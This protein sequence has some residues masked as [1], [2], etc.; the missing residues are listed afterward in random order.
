MSESLIFVVHSARHG[1]AVMRG[2]QQAQSINE[3]GGSARVLGARSDRPSLFA[4]RNRTVVLVKDVIIDDELILAL[5]L[6]GNRLVWDAVDYCAHKPQISL[7]E[8]PVQ[9]LAGLAAAEL[10]TDV[11]AMTT[12]TNAV[13]EAAFSGLR[14]VHRVDHQIDRRLDGTV[15]QEP[16]DSFGVGYFGAPEN[17]PAWAD[18]LDGLD[19]LLVDTASFAELV[20]RARNLAVHADFRNPLRDRRDHKPWTKVATTVALGAVPIA[21]DTAA[22]LDALGQDYPLLFDGSS[23]GFTEAVETAARSWDEDRLSSLRDRL[24]PLRHRS[25]PSEV[26]RRL[27]E[28]LQA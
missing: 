12:A 13:V 10:V 24:A 4:L 6:G 16:A 28:A 27:V 19:R 1:S 7:P 14:S 20:P 25:D 3:I 11:L 26:A 15:Q 21:E 8:S 23:I 17:L 18:R 5:A 22:N 2:Y 9:H